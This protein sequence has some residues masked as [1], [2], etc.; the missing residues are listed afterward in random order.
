MIEKG[1]ISPVQLAILMHPTI[2]ATGILFVPALVGKHAERDMWFAPFLA[3]PIGIYVLWVVYQIYKLY[4]TQTVIKYSESILGRWLGKAIGFLFIFY[5]AYE[6]STILREYGDFIIGGFFPSTPMAVIIGTM[7]LV[8]AFAVRGG[9]EV[10]VRVAQFLIPPIS[11]LI[12]VMF[13]LLLRELDPQNMF[14]IF[15]N[16]LGPSFKGSVV[17]MG[18]FSQFFLCAFLFPFLNQ[19]HQAQGV[20]WGLLSLL[21]VLMALTFTNLV[22]LF[23]FGDTTSKMQYP[24]FTASKYISV[25]NFVEHLEALAATIWVSGVFIKVTVFYYVTVLG[26]AQWLNLQ[27]YRPLVLPYG[28]LFTI[29]SLWVAPNVVELAQFLET[30]LPFHSLVVQL[31]IP[32]LLWGI[33]LVRRRKLHKQGEAS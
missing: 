29:V 1:K 9:L 12:F 2:V 23:L 27:D 26:T 16:G 5:Y 17:L 32:T 18:W 22:T 25:A 4:P 6:T 24:V 30:V 13:F 28:F 21:T 14:P 8:S 7:V 19:K 33:A 15:E 20:K 11:I 3:V 10:F 31:G